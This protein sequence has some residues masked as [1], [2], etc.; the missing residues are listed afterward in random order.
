M[1]F[2]GN[3]SSEIG[4]VRVSM[5]EPRRDSAEKPSQTAPTVASPG[6]ATGAVRTP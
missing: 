6:L 3:A 4:R 2:D 1:K 5:P